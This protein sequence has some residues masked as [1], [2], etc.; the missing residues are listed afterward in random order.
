MNHSILT[1]SPYFVELA[2]NEICRSHPSIIVLDTLSPGCLLIQAPVSFDQLTRPFREH[3]PIYLHHLFP[4]QKTV[5]LDISSV[6]QAIE[7]LMS[8]HPT[9]TIQARILPDMVNGADAVAMPPFNEVVQFFQRWEGPSPA[10]TGKI[11]SVAIA[12]QHTKWRVF[13]G[14][15]WAN[16]NISPYAGG[17]RPYKVQMPNRAGYKLL[18]ALTDFGIRLRE[19]DHALDLGAAPGAWTMVLRQR[20]LKVT[21][22]APTEMYPN[23]LDDPM[24]MYRGMTAENYLPQAEGP[25]DVITNDMRMDAQDSSR[26]MVQ[27]AKLLRP[28]GLAI[29]TL[30]LRQPNMRRLMD[31]SFR[32]LRQAYK[33]MQVRQLVSNRQEVCLFLR[34]KIE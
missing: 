28:D 2:V 26:L 4:I 29:V 19:G 9:A 3:L 33:I 5:S 8:Q 6:K 18:E 11:L 27:Y 25:F 23:L 1:C 16:Q 34:P 22:V 30:K 24:V 13:M 20:G 32:I 21:A 14:V 12:R 10:V 15:S 17:V 31:H 7:K